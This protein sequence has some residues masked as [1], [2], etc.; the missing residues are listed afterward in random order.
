MASRPGPHYPVYINIDI[1]L[2]IAM[3]L[4]AEVI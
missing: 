3:I 1:D 4:C 2:G